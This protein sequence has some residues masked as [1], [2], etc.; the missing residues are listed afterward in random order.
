MS[1]R[2]ADTEFTIVIPFWEL[3]LVEPEI[4]IAEGIEAAIPEAYDD[5]RIGW[6]TNFYTTR[7]DGSEGN[8]IRI[9]QIDG[10]R[11]LIRLT[12]E[13]VDPDYYD[14]SNPRSRL[15]VETW[16]VKNDEGKRS[17]Q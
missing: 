12:G 11:L 13:I 8:V 3:N 16:F 6:L 1:P 15:L 4:E 7:H 14:D 9:L 10:D 17:M 5:D 2:S